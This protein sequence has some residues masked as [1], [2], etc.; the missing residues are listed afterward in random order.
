V[1]PLYGEGMTK[2]VLYYGFGS[3][4]LVDLWGWKA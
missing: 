4:T 3:M 1:G 2:I